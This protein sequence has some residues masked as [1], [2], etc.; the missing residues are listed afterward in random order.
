MNK[1]VFKN[2][3]HYETLKAKRVFWCCYT[4]DRLLGVDM[5]RT[6]FLKEDSITLDF[7]E[8]YE[9]DGW[10]SPYAYAMI[11]LAMCVSPLT[12]ESSIDA[13]DSLTAGVYESLRK[14]DAEMYNEFQFETDENLDE[15]ADP[16]LAC[17]VRLQYYHCVLFVFQKSVLMFALIPKNDSRSTSNDCRNVI[18]AVKGIVTAINSLENYFKKRNSKT[19]GTPWWLT[20]ITLH[21]ACTI[22]LMFINAG[23]DGYI[24]LRK[25]L[26]IAMNL[27]DKMVEDGG[28]SMAKECQWSLRTMSHLVYMR[29]HESADLLAAA[30]INHGDISANKRHFAPTGHFDKNGNVVNQVSDHISTA[31]AQSSLLASNVAAF[32]YNPGVSRPEST[33]NFSSSGD[34]SAPAFDSPG[35]GWRNLD[36]IASSLDWFDAWTFDI[37]SSVASFL[38][39]DKQM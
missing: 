13:D 6:Y 28:F 27:V 32:Q 34:P 4:W 12:F 24:E 9:D 1:A 35:A 25:Y 39:G 31:P 5:G 30:G 21:V 19:F 16:A 23:L 18:T 14:W 37:E 10:L 3:G 15:A 22:L 7:P 29:F 20:L 33:S 11:R 2:L 17:H 8:R 36:P 26:K 38:E